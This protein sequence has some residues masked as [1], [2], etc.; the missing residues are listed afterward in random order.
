MNSRFI[1]TEI[2]GESPIGLVCWYEILKSTSCLLLICKVSHSHECMVYCCFILK[3]FLKTQYFEEDSLREI[4]WVGTVQMLK[5]VGWENMK[6]II[7][8]P[9]TEKKVISM[10]IPISIGSELDN[11]LILQQSIWGSY[12]RSVSK[13]LGCHEKNHMISLSLSY[14]IYKIKSII[15]SPKQ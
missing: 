7:R 13:Y 15:P 10:N 3:C 2:Y 12:L 14:L 5:P 4:S 9:K 1:F 11:N 6:L 8:F